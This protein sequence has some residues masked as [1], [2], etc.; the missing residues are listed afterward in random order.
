MS[1][2]KLQEYAKQNN[3]LVDKVFFQYP[4]YCPKSKVVHIWIAGR[5][6]LR[7]E[8][9]SVADYDQ[10]LESLSQKALKQL[11]KSDIMIWEKIR[12]HAE[13]NGLKLKH[14]YVHD[15]METDADYWYYDIF[16]QVGENMYRERCRSDDNL[17]QDL[18]KKICNDLKIDFSS[19]GCD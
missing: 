12:Q 1:W 10:M 18:Y 11:P 19:V 5:R 2:Q 17:E 6:F 15:E 9:Y 4:R 8:K 13:T 7:T 14:K 16:V 3:V